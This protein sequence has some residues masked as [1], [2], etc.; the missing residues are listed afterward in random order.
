MS[1]RLK[2]SAVTFDTP[3]AGDRKLPLGSNRQREPTAIAFAAVDVIAA[4]RADRVDEAAVAR[5]IADRAQRRGVA[6]R[7][8]DRALQMAR[9]S[10]RRLT[11]SGSPRRASITPILGWLVI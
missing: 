11:G 6:H 4:R 9:R 3:R 10:R 7:H 5:V 1:W 2:P 8:I